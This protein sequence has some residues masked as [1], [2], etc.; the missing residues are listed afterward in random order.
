MKILS[1]CMSYWKD[2]EFSNVRLVYRGRSTP[3]KLTSMLAELWKVESLKDP[4]IT[5]W[6]EILHLQMTGEKKRKKNRR[7]PIFVFVLKGSSCPLASRKKRTNHSSSEFTN[8][9]DSLT[10]FWWPFS[11][12][13][14]LVC[15][16]FPYNHHHLRWPVTQMVVNHTSIDPPA[17][18]QKHKNRWSRKNLA[19][20]P[21]NNVDG[22]PKS[23]L[24]ND[25]PLVAFLYVTSTLSGGCFPWS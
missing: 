9:Q 7:V 22:L 6:T 18:Q 2:G 8:T 14:R 24:H 1:R 3:S 25:F 11:P 21:K 13:H 19:G 12:L 20:M 23:S 17:N 15:R 16:G 4:K 5:S 10:I